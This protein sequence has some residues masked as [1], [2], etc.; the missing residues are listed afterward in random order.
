MGGTLLKIEATIKGQHRQIWE[1][2][3]M[4]EHITKWNFASDDWCCP[5]ASVNLKN[6]GQYLA[7]MEAK[8]GSFGF[9]FVGVYDEVIPETSLTMTLGDGRRVF[10]VFKDLGGS[11]RVTTTFEA[12][13]EHPLEMQRE[14]WQAILNNFKNYVESALLE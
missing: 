14:G 4:P 2:W 8:D 7:R 6:G 9:D 5:S 1:A 10:T 12:E 3:T 11:T 13:T